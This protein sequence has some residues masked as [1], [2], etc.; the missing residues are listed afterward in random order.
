MAIM[1]AITIG[2]ITTMRGMI[3]LITTST[4]ADPN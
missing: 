4:A 2:T 1:I 3:A